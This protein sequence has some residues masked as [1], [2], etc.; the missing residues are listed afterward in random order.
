MWED[1]KILEQ[2]TVDVLAPRGLAE[3]RTPRTAFIV[4]CLAL[5]CMIGSV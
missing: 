2:L 3:A 1:V 4:T 5:F